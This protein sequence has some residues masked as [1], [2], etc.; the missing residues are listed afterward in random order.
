MS[1]LC[2]LLLL[3]LLQCTE[4]ELLRIQYRNWHEGGR[5]THDQI[6]QEGLQL[7]RERIRMNGHQDSM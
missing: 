6:S 5:L 2:I 1:L 3:L 4:I 7:L